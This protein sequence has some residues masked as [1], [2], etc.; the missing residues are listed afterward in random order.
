MRPRNTLRLSGLAMVLVFAL[1][2]AATTALFTRAFTPSVPVLVRADKAGLLLTTGSDVKLRGVV[3]GEVS[4]VT[5]ERAGGALIHLDLDPDEVSR[6]P[7]DVTAIIDPTTIFGR[8][9]IALL[10][11]EHPSTRAITAGAVVDAPDEGPEVA[12]TFDKL[13]DLLHTIQPAKLNST[14]G[15][16]SETLRGRGDVLGDYAVRLRDYLRS[17]NPSLPTLAD[18]LAKTDDV[19]ATYAQATPD[20]LNTAGNATK[21][22][23][24]VVE[25]QLALDALLLDVT[26]FGRT[27]ESVVA[28][29]GQHIV[30][31]LDLFDPTT[32]LLSRY[33]PMFPC[34]F[35]GLDETRKLAGRMIGG[36]K[37]GLYAH[38]SFE[39]GLLPYDT[40]KDL[41]EVGGSNQPSCNGLP[42]LEGDE[43]PAP[44][45]EHDDGVEPR[46]QKFP[47]RLGTAL[48]GPQEAGR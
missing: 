20:L 14:L 31:T 25:Q 18:D 19:V 40:A 3:V 8:K 16:V 42:K 46:P 43:L 47:S 23:N 48:F 28:E 2:I 45:V 34:F 33:S 39:P 27:G 5:H 26:T 9:G 38:G 35:Q 32:R 29:N 22:G 6:I 12:I 13:V 44:L 37:P 30:E 11:Q 24:T 17:L 21:T 41:P 36:E 15:A 1:I 10:A 7:S 4:E